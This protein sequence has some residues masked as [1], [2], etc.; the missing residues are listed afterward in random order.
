MKEKTFMKLR[1]VIFREGKGN[2]GFI[3]AEQGEIFEI[4][5]FTLVEGLISLIATYYALQISCPKITVAAMELLFIQEALLEFNDKENKNHQI[6][7]AN[8]CRI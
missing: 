8:Q 7:I 6:Y 3:V 2:Q 1:L 5:E 4:T